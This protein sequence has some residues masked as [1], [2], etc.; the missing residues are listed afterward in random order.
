MDRLATLCELADAGSFS[1]ASMGD[2]N[3]ASLMSRQIRELESFFGIDLVRR[4]GRGLELTPAGLELAAVGRGHFKGLSDFAARC[5]KKEWCAR[6]VASNSVAQWLL[7]PRI[8]AVIER[9]PE[10]R[11]EIH[12][13]QTREMVGMTREGVFDLALVRKDTLLP[14]LQSA[15]LGEIHHSLFIP[16][17]IAPRKPKSPADAILSLPVA[18]PIG[19]RVRENLDQVAAAA[20]GTPKIA[21]ACSSYMQ[22]A[23]LVRSGVCAAALPDTAAASLRDI[24]TH[25]L[26]L[27]EK[28]MLCLAWTARNADTRPALAGLI[29]VLA[30]V[31][32]VS[33]E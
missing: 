5:R 27:P 16:K 1:K 29:S 20:G 13:Q 22:A 11:F 15:E 4:K 17:T 30:E 23:S 25:R 28:F 12:H 9:C 10:V 8:G 32:R 24:R 14:G 18:L 3:T 2:S 26:P 7:L 6:I 21:V 33:R 31:L 19:G